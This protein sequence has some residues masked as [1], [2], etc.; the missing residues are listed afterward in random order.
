M[1]KVLESVREIRSVAADSGVSRGSVISL[2]TQDK[3][4]IE[5][6]ASMASL[7]KAVG[8]LRIDAAAPSSGGDGPE[9]I[10]KQDIN[11]CTVSFYPKSK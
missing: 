1:A 3:V 6:E 4:L 11:H 2:S 7:V 8:S 9:P 5:Y 10:L